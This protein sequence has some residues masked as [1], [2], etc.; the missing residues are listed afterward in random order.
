MKKPDI[1]QIVIALLI[2]AIIVTLGVFVY[3]LFQKQIGKS[4]LSV[5]VV[6]GKANVL[7][8]N[9][10][11]GETPVYTE[12][13]FA[14]QAKIDV[15]GQSSTYSTSIKPASGTMAVVIRDLGVNS[16]F[17]SGQNIWFEKI[18]GEDAYI[19]V[20]SPDVEEVSVIV[21]G[22][23][24]GKTPVK[25]STNDLLEKNEE[26]KYTISFIKDGYEEQEANITAKA[27]YQL[28]IRADMFLKPIPARVSNFDDLAE[29]VGFLDFSD[30]NNPAFLDKKAWASAIN[31][32]LSTRG[33]NNIGNSTVEKFS[34]F[35]DDAGKVYNQDGNEISTDDVTFE[36]GTYVAYLGSQQTQGLSDEAKITVE[37]LTG[38]TVVDGGTD[39]GSAQDGD[40]QSGKRIKVSPNS[41][42]FLRVRQ[43]PSVNET[44]LSRVNVGTEWDVKGEQNGWYKIEYETGKEGWVSGQFVEV[45]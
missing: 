9:K 37:K 40:T 30:V 42:G 7:I 27:G 28:N 6:Y 11:K 34:Y 1:Y 4:A 26:D 23:E 44:E 5:E 16:S 10:E 33:S 24:M 18:G 43:G 38:K 17:S 31:Y 22:I 35:I 12:E 19:S 15:N 2:V 25:F 8:N 41:L 29:D 36:K 32:W 3:N 20:I 21:D 13:V 14:K 45:L 39:E